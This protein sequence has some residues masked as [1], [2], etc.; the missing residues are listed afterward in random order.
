[1]TLIPIHSDSDSKPKYLDKSVFCSS[2]V[3]ASYYLTPSAILYS[4]ES[5][6]PALCSPFVLPPQRSAEEN[7]I[8]MMIFN[9]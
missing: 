4:H 9:S 7:R 5:Q 3:W 8:S 2:E 1:M 6:P